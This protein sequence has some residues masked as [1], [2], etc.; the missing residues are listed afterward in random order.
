MDFEPILKEMV[1]NI[2]GNVTED[3]YRNIS[4]YV[5]QHSTPTYVSYLL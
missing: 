5:D 2:F 4:G 1:G 3:Y